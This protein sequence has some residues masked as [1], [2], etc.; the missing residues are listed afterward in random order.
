M[1]LGLGLV[2]APATDSIMGSLPLSKAGVGS[3]VNDTTRMVGGALGVAVIG[4]L[5][6]ST[7][8]SKIEAFGIASGLPTSAIDAIRGQLGAALA[9]AQQLP[10]PIGGPD[11]TLIPA[12]KEAFVS[13]MHSAVLVAAAVAIVGVVVAA[14]WLPARPRPEDV[15]GQ[16]AEAASGA[17]FDGA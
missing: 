4:S 14:V 1:A 17:E 12:A 7:Y 5:M 6:S 9:A 11:G 2:M 3:A 10:A 16:E 8:G 13:G 15:A